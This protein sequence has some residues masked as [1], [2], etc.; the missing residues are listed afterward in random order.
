MRSALLLGLLVGCSSAGGSGGQGLG[1]PCDATAMLCAA[2]GSCDYSSATP[3]CLDD[4]ADPDGDG[5]PNKLD[6]CPTVTGGMYDED[7]DG[8]GDECDRC[9]IA[10]P[11]AVPDRDGDDVD[12]PCDPDPST[13]GDKILLF[14][15]FNGSL[16]TT[17]WKP[18]LAGVWTVEGGEL[19]ARLPTQAAQSFL[20]ANVV[21]EPNISVQMSY[22]VD[23]VEPG[24]QTH[25]V[26]AQMFDIR[27]AGVAGFDCGVVKSDLGTAGEVVDLETDHGAVSQPAMIGAFES[28]RL[29]R[30]AAYASGA[31]VGCVVIGDNMA[32]ATIQDSITPA[33]LGSVKITAR[34]VTARYQWILVVGHGNATGGGP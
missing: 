26:S 9:P 18:D 14:D 19:V 8:I 23:K 17:R 7:N 6:H 11:P 34:A 28:A 30:S 20:A 2:G 10:K 13:P 12:S 15:G 33:S 32:L 4:T 22:R 21:P 27:P 16:D 3:T 25:I 5:I 29:Y 31:T 24:S 1:E